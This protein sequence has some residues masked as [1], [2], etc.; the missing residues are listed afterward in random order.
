M[1]WTI[2]WGVTV[3]SNAVDWSCGVSAGCTARVANFRQRCVM[4]KLDVIKN[5]VLK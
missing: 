1:Y 3:L 5:N 2:A 4:R